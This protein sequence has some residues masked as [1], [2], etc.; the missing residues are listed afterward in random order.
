MMFG[1][2]LTAVL[3]TGNCGSACPLPPAAKDRVEVQ[4]IIDRGDR[5]VLEIKAVT[6]DGRPAHEARGFLQFEH[7]VHLGGRDLRDLGFDRPDYEARS[8]LI[9]PEKVWTSI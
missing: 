1:A 5:F 4:K 6:K 9:T 7:K 3:L 8:S 2:L